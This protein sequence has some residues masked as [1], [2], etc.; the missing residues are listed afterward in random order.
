MNLKIE[1]GAV[2]QQTRIAKV[3]TKDGSAIQEQL[4][5]DETRFALLANLFACEGNPGQVKH[6]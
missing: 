1:N 6:I 3:N 4:P 2:D 5:N